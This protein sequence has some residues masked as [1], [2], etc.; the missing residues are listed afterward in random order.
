MNRLSTW[1]LRAL[2]LALPLVLIAAAIPLLIDGVAYEQAF[3]TAIYMPMNVALPRANYTA[4]A[5][6]LAHGAAANGEREILEAEALR[7][8]GADPSRVAA[9][10]EQG[11]SHAPASARGWMLLAET[12]APTDRA[13]AASALSAALML[14]PNEYFLVGRLVRDAGALWDV[15]PKDSR[16]LAVD[17]APVLWRD[18][19]L[20][21]ALRPILATKGGAALMTEAFRYAPEDLRALNRYVAEQRLEDLRR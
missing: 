1:S 20:R 16:D 15:L 4:A 5:Q 2:L 21:Y 10:L 19:N 17:D 8:S 12:L 7:L 6:A 11:L 14:A 13:K 9:A 3:P 18:P